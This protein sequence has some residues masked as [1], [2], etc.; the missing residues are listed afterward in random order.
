MSERLNLLTASYQ[1]TSQSTKQN[2]LGMREMQARAYA[3]RNKPYI[4]IKSP[5]ASGK[6]RALMYLSLFKMHEQGLRK[7]IVA[8]PEMSIGSSFKSTKLSADGFPWDW[9]VEPGLNLCSDLND[10]VSTLVDFLSMENQDKVV[11]CT[12]A[13]LRFAYDQLGPT[14]FNGVLVGIDEFHHVST[15]EDNKLGTLIDGL[16]NQ[17]S[18]EI[19]AMTGSYFRGDAAP[20]LMPEDEAKF[21]KVTYTY[22]EQLNGYT[23]LKTLGLDYFFYKGD[24]TSSLKDVLNEHHKTIVHIPNVNS[25]E[26]HLNKNEA[27]DAVIDALGKEIDRDPNTGVITVETHSGRIIKVA[28]LVDE[29]K[30]MRPRT[31]AYLANIKHRDDMDVIV[32]LGMAKEGFDWIYCEHVLTIGFRNSMTEVIQIIGRT[33]RDC[34]GKTHAQFT[35]LIARPDAS[36]EDIRE[37]VNTFLKAITLSLLMEQ[38]ITPKINFKSSDEMTEADLANKYVIQEKT[39][40]PLSQRGKQV[41]NQS[42]DQIILKLGSDRRAQ[43][44]IV[45]TTD[46]SY[47]HGVV[48]PSIIRE[49]HP[50]LDDGEVGAIS[51]R[52]SQSLAI[53]A[54]GGITS[55]DQI[56]DQDVIDDERLFTRNDNGELTEITALDARE[57]ADIGSEVIRERELASYS[58]LPLIKTSEPIQNRKFIKMG[59]KFLDVDKLGIDLIYQINPFQNAFNVISKNISSDV[60]KTIQNE[61]AA[62]KITMTEDELIDIWPKVKAFIQLTKT[63]P[64]DTSSDFNERRYAE[65]IA[66]AN[67]LHQARSREK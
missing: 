45:E 23:Y 15:N 50:E 9:Q 47:I 4:L 52:I 62:T 43:H 2:E 39:G 18:A 42:M 8:V 65:A 1:Q 61:I 12:H 58:A 67:K 24:Y 66:L 34:P 17:S 5:P 41:L 56:G 11:V 46:P 26:A 28:D 38:V 60:L 29:N 14:A 44:S 37:A 7:T 31:Q 33:T 16:M 19:I 54:C 55:I 57:I 13:T 21:T 32:A 59:G 53:N 3:E 51:A 64:S 48:L 36:N 40:R 49:I 35:N 6:S 27:V 20:I 10:K 25:H 30:I 63:K 22:F